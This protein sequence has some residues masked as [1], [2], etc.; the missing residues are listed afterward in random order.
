MLNRL[1]R[2]LNRCAKDQ[3]ANSA[4]FSDLFCVASNLARHAARSNACADELSPVAKSLI[5]VLQGEM[6]AEGCRPG[7]GQTPFASAQT[8]R[9]PNTCRC[10]ME[11]GTTLVGLGPRARSRIELPTNHYL[12]TIGHVVWR[13][14][15]PQSFLVS[16]LLRPRSA[17]VAKPIAALLSS[18][19]RRELLL[20]PGK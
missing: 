7:A 2:L 5:P 11:L 18:P 20:H 19:R 6:H 3:N 17:L 9:P 12:L 16:A 13:R 14:S 1:L 4:N 10:Q 8:T 15:I